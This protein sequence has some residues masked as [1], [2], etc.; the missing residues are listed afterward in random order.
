[1]NTQSDRLCRQERLAAI[2]QE[3]A[4][5]KAERER[6]LVRAFFSFPFHTSAAVSRLKL[7]PYEM[8]GYAVQILDRVRR[9]TL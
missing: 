7:N 8:D 1:M 5:D 6:R 3:K 2:A 4:L 9:C